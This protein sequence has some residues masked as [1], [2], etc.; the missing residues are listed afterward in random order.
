MTNDDQ[1]AATTA[2][3]GWDTRPRAREQGLVTARSGDE[4]LVYDLERHIAHRLNHTAA[5]L[6]THCD[7]ERSVADLR[8]LLER[9]VGAPL[10]T[11]VVWYG[12]RR[13]DRKRL[14]GAGTKLPDD[15]VICS[16]RELLRRLTRAGVVMGIPV[17][18][19]LAIPTALLALTSCLPSG[20][21]CTSDPRPCCAPAVC[22]PY[23]GPAF[24]CQ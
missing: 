3:A 24:I 2:P 9:D 8:V 11:D 21:D 17:V 5:L 7:G 18:A 20:A 22:S 15:A 19:S 1:R 4:L 6:W 23:H 13:L 16:R 10:S 12:I 14:L